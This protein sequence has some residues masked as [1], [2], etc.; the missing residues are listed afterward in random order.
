MH[1]GRWI[2][3]LGPAVVAGRLEPGPS[4]GG[5]SHLRFQPHRDLDFGAPLLEALGEAQPLYRSRHPLC[6]RRGDYGVVWHALVRQPNVVNPDSTSPPLL[7]G[8]WASAA[9]VLLYF[10]SL[11][12]LI[13]IIPLAYL[14]LLKC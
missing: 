5:D 9:L 1:Y 12:E 13:A 14:Y 6:G 11:L 4:D 8:G 10:I 2:P 7:L 3:G